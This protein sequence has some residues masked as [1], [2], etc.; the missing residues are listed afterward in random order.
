M[1]RSLRLIPVAVL[2]LAL[3]A[4]GSTDAADDDAAG[5]APSATD[6]G[7]R[8]VEHDMGSTEVPAE[9]ER[10]VVLDS[11]H[12]DASLSL[13]VTPVGAVQASVDEGLPAYLGDRT[14]GIEI[15][16]TIEEPNLEAIA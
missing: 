14:E 9:P 16:G 4:C 5:A 1:R 7:S 2:A 3:A 8:T 13:G 11:P 12:L 15:V 10:V 6:G